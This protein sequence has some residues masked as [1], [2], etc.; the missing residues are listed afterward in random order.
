[1]GILHFIFGASEKQRRQ[2]PQIE[3]KTKSE[4]VFSGLPATNE[5][6]PAIPDSHMLEGRVQVIDGNTI[7]IEDTKI[8]LAGIEAPELSEPWGQKPKLTMVEICNDHI[9]SARLTGE[10]SFDQLIGTCHLPDG[11][12]IGAELIKRGLALD[13]GVYSKGDYRHLEPMGTRGKLKRILKKRTT[14]LSSI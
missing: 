4:E 2:P 9:I 13:G 5:M 6:L 3:A 1:M 14:A 11:R 10:R 8:R 12:D 7:A